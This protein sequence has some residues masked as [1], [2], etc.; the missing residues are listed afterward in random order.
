[1]TNFVG[2]MVLGSVLSTIGPMAI[3]AIAATLLIRVF[4]GRKAAVVCALVAVAVLIGSRFL[5]RLG[6]GISGRMGHASSA[7][8][9]AAVKKAQQRKNRQKWNK[10]AEQDIDK[11]SALLATQANAMGGPGGMGVGMG[12][13]NVKVPHISAPKY[14]A[15]SGPLFGGTPGS[16]N[17]TVCH[18]AQVSAA[19]PAATPDA[20]MA[21]LTPSAPAAAVGGV[22]PSAPDAS[23]DGEAEADSS[24]GAPPASVATPAATAGAAA[25][26]SNNK[27]AASTPSQSN[28]LQTGSAGGAKPS[29][30]GNPA[31]GAASPENASEE[32]TRSKAASPHAGQ[33][34]ASTHSPGSSDK[35]PVN[36]PPPSTG[37]SAKSGPNQSTGRTA[38]NTHQ[39]PKRGNGLA[40]GMAQQNPHNS[41]VR[42]HRPR[43]Q[44]TEQYVMPAMPGG[45]G[46]MHSMN[47]QQYPGMGNFH[48]QGG[49][50]MNGGMSNGVH[51]RGR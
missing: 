27:N 38:R 7:K 39:S 10:G 14:P 41:Q 6:A 32:S 37:N 24:G 2:N 34:A 50:P 5:P 29:P 31:T 4:K 19:A 9:A 11:A 3:A 16:Q 18:A 49:H 45:M 25:A 47:G 21:A 43:Y 36:T 28:T 42:P 23:A 33:A 26:S 12:L 15:H 44:P 48:P 1:M 46:G 40:G 8:G 51:H 13:P 35:P 20:Q 30:T 22:A 17:V